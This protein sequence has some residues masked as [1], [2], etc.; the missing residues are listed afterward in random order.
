MSTQGGASVNGCVVVVYKDIVAGYCAALTSKLFLGVHNFGS[1]SHCY[2]IEPTF[3]R[4]LFNRV[5]ED[6]STCFKHLPHL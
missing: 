2:V 4:V 5:L 3:N 1:L 6:V